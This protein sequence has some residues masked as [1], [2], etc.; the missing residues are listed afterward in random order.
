MSYALGLS[1]W[2]RSDSSTSVFLWLINFQYALFIRI[3]GF[4]SCCFPNLQ[5][6]R[7]FD[8]YFYRCIP[9]LCL[10]IKA[11]LNI[12]QNCHGISCCGR[13]HSSMSEFLCTLLLKLKWNK[14][15]ILHI[16][17]GIFLRFYL[18]IYLFIHLFIYLFIYS[19]VYLFLAGVLF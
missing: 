15:F 13:I 19:F 17:S 6:W 8:V 16:F 12:S 5:L 18:F 9:F 2:L 11:P 3:S 7:E 4:I 14:I 1:T 10:E